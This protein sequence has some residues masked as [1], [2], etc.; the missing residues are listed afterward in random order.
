[1][2][3]VA[4]LQILFFALCIIAMFVWGGWWITKHIGN[5]RL[6]IFSRSAILALFLTP[7]IAFAGHAAIVLP[8]VV[9]ILFFLF[10]KQPVWALY[11]GVV[12][13]LVA[14]LAVF[15]I[16]ITVYELTRRFKNSKSK[17]LS[18]LGRRFGPE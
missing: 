3:D 11:Y 13:I 18:E 17:I 15:T 12:P 2:D 6:R 8:A 4:T 1:M 5:P 10:S 16:W 9:V 7:S 14:L